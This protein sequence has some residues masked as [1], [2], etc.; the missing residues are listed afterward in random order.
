MNINFL[1]QAVEIHLE[2]VPESTGGV[3][4]NDAT[5]NCIDP[6]NHNENDRQIYLMEFT[7]PACLTK[8]T[9]S[10]TVLSVKAQ[11]R[12]GKSTDEL[13]SFLHELFSV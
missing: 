7:T 10:D 8:E 13:Y 3:A 2:E 1:N 6:V 5:G 4:V 9:T 12:S 11:E